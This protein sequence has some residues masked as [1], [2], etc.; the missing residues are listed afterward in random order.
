[1]KRKG[2]VLTVL[3]VAFLIV[4]ALMIISAYQYN[5]ATKEGALLFAGKFGR[6]L[7]QLGKNTAQV[8]GYAVRLRWTPEINTSNSTNNTGVRK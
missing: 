8:V 4:G 7:F 1:M 2:G 6:W 5:L 3:I